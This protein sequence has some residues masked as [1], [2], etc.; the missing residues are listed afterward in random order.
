VSADAT[1]SVSLE[2]ESGQVFHAKSP[3]GASITLDGDTVRGFSPMESLLSSVSACM[4]I[5]IV[6]ILGKMRIELGGLHIAVE[7]D[8]AAEPPRY[9]ERIRMR[10][11]FEGNLPRDK[12]ERAVELSLEKYCSV[13]H[14]MRRDI[15]V[16]TTI[17][18]S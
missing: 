6:H 11:R 15:D 12:A 14:S 5:D 18:M 4:G 7:G 3:A 17:E 8:R 16:E 9:F 2:W 10:F 1:R 13:F